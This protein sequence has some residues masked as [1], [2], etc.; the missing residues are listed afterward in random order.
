MSMINYKLEIKGTKENVTFGPRKPGEAGR[1]ILIIKNA[2]GAIED[3]SILVEGVDAPELNIYDPNG[4]FDCLEGKKV[5]DTQAATFDNTMQN[6]LRKYQL[7]NQFYILCYYFV[8]YAIPS[9]MAK[10]NTIL[11]EGMLESPLEDVAPEA[12]IADWV[13]SGE[14]KIHLS[15]GKTIDIGS[16]QGE[17]ISEYKSNAFLSNQLEIIVRMFDSEF[18]NLGEATLAIMHGWMPRTSLF[19]TGYYYDPRTFEKEEYAYDIVLLGLFNAFKE[20]SLS[21]KVQAEYEKQPATIDP[22][23]GL[24]KVSEGGYNYLDD[25][26]RQ[27][28]AKERV[29]FAADD[30]GA[31]QDSSVTTPFDFLENHFGAIRY[32][33]EARPWN[34]PTGPYKSPLYASLEIV[35]DKFPKP[36]S[37]ISRPEKQNKQALERIFEPDPFVN[38]DPFVIDEHRIGFFYK[39]AYN[40]ENLPPFSGSENYEQ[41]IRKL[42]DMA[43]TQVMSYYG[44]PRI[45]YLDTREAEY[46]TKFIGDMMQYFVEPNPSSDTLPSS[47]AYPRPAHDGS[48]LSDIYK[49]ELKDKIWVLATKT[50]HEA[51]E[52]GDSAEIYSEYERDPDGVLW[53]GGLIEPLIKFE[54]FRTPSLRRGD[55]Y[56]AKFIV[57]KSKLDYISKGFIER[58]TEE[59]E[60]ALVDATIDSVPKIDLLCTGS[61]GFGNSTENSERRYE[62]FKSIASKNKKEIARILR[63]KTLEAYNTQDFRGASNIDLGIFGSLGAENP[64]AATAAFLS[65]KLTNISQPLNPK[66]KSATSLSISYPDLKER[67]RSASD[68]LKKAFEFAIQEKIEFKFKGKQTGFNGVEKAFILA[69]VPIEVKRCIQKYGRS[70]FDFNDGASGM[71]KPDWVPDLNPL[72]QFS[73]FGLNEIHFKFKKLDGDCGLE[74]DSIR[75]GNNIITKSMIKEYASLNDPTVVSYLSQIYDMTGGTALDELKGGFITSFFTPPPISCTDIGIGK[76]GLGFLTRYTPC[77]KGEPMDDE[78]IKRWYQEEVEDPFNAWLNKSGNNLNSMFDPQFNK[79][80]LLSVLGKTADLKR[81]YRDFRN[82]I[83][84]SGFLCNILKCLQLPAINL[85][86]PELNLP[87][88]P[89]KIN[90]FGWYVGFVK[91]LIEAFFEVLVRILLSFFQMILDFLNFPF[92]EEQLRDELFGELSGSTPLLQEALVDGLLDIGLSKESMP[93]AKG[94]ISGAMSFLTGREICNLLKGEE[95]NPQSMS[96]LQDL[97]IKRGLGDDLGSPAAIRNFFESISIFIPDFC[98]DLESA[99]WVI[100]TT[101]CKETTSAAEQYRRRMMAGEATQE[102]MD[103][104]LELLDKNLLD[105]FEKLQAFS[106][107][108]IAGLLPDVV[109]F[110]NP[111]ALLNKLPNALEDQANQTIKNM[112]EPAKMSYL[113]SL[114]SFGPGLFFDT[115]RMPTPADNEFE[116]EAFITVTTIINNLNNYA[117]MLDT[118]AGREDADSEPELIAQLCALHTIYELEEDA[119]SGKKTLSAYEWVGEGTYNARKNLS[120]LFLENEA[121]NKKFRKL[122]FQQAA[123]LNSPRDTG[124][125]PIIYKPAG[126]S[127]DFYFNTDEDGNPISEKIANE[128]GKNMF[129]FESADRARKLSPR[130]G[131]H[132]LEGF[133]FQINYLIEKRA[134][135]DILDPDDDD[136]KIQEGLGPG[137]GKRTL[138]TAIK[139][140][141]DKMQMDLFSSLNVVSTPKVG[142][143]YLGTIRELFSQA[144]ETLT[145]NLKEGNRANELINIQS[146][147][148]EDNQ[149]VSSLLLNLKKGSLQATVKYN[150]F[151][152]VNSAEFDPYSIEIY[153]DNMFNRTEENP[154]TIEVCD[155]VPGPDNDSDSNQSNSIYREAIEEMNLTAGKNLYTRRELFARK[156]MSSLY[157]MSQKYYPSPAQNSSTQGFIKNL[158]PKKSDSYFKKGLVNKLYNRSTEGVFEQIFFALENSRIYDEESYYPGLNSRVAGQMYINQDNSC[159]KNRY[160]VSQLGLLSF[161]KMITDEIPKQLTSELSKPENAPENIDYDSP[162][163]VEKAIKN[164][165]FIGFIRIC[166]VELLLKGSLAYSVWDFEGVFDEKIFEEFVFEYIKSELLRKEIMKQNWEQMS[167]N[168]TGIQNPT[169]AL[170]KLVRNQSMKMLDV[171]KRIYRNK[172]ADIVDY[173]DWYSK[174]FIPQAHCS[175]N[176]AIK[177]GEVEE[178]YT[179]T[180]LQGQIKDSSTREQGRMKIDKFFWSHPLADERN[181]IIEDI[182]RRI[183]DVDIRSTSQDETSKIKDNATGL[184]RGNDPFFHIEHLVEVQGPLAA[185]ESIVIPGSLITESILNVDISRGEG[186]SDEARA[187]KKLTTKVSTRTPEKLNIQNSRNRTSLPALGLGDYGFEARPSQP[188]GSAGAAQEE[189]ANLVGGQGDVDPQKYAETTEVFNV[190]DF[191]SALNFEVTDKKMARFLNHMQGLMHYPGEGE[192]N[193][194]TEYPIPDAENPEFSGYPEEIKKLP[195]KFIKKT[196]RII[197]FKKDFVSGIFDDFIDGSSNFG[198]VE[199]YKKAMYKGSKSPSEHF[200]VVAPNGALAQGSLEAFRRFSAWKGELYEPQEEITEYYILPEN[201]EDLYKI[202][203]QIL[204]A[205]EAAGES[206]DGFELVDNTFAERSY[207]ADEMDME[208]AYDLLPEEAQ[209]FIEN[210]VGLKNDGDSVKVSFGRSFNN[211]RAKSDKKYGF[212]VPGLV[213]VNT[214]K[215]GNSAGVSHKESSL[216]FREITEGGKLTTRTSDARNSEVIIF[217]NKIGKFTSEQDYKNAINLLLTG[218]ETNSQ[219]AESLSSIVD[220]REE[221]WV[222]TVYEFSGE[223]AILA[224]V[225][226][227]YTIGETMD[228]AVFNFNPTQQ[229]KEAWAKVLEKH[230]VDSRLIFNQN[231]LVSYGR[232]FWPDDGQRGLSTGNE[233]DDISSRI[234]SRNMAIPYIARPMGIDKHTNRRLTSKLLVRAN[235]NTPGTPLFDDFMSLYAPF[236]RKDVIGKDGIATSTPMSDIPRPSAYAS[237]I[238]SN[239]N[240]IRNSATVPVWSTFNGAANNIHDGRTDDSTTYRDVCLLLHESPLF[241]PPTDNRDTSVITSTTGLLPPNVYKIPLRVLITQVYIKGSVKKAYCKVVPPKYIKNLKS[242]PADNTAQNLPEEVR[243]NIETL[244]QSITKICN[245]Y[246]Q[247]HSALEEIAGITTQDLQKGR[248]HIVDKFFSGFNRAYPEFTKDFTLNFDESINQENAEVDSEFSPVKREAS[249]LELDSPSQFCSV[250][251]IYS[252][253]F[254]LET[255]QNYWN[256]KEELDKLFA[257]D[258]GFLIRRKDINIEFNF[259]KD[260]TLPERIRHMESLNYFY[261]IPSSANIASTSTTSFHFHRTVFS[262]N[263]VLQWFLRYRHHNSL[264]GLMTPLNTQDVTTKNLGYGGKQKY[265]MSKVGAKYSQVNGTAQVKQNLLSSFPGSNAFRSPWQMGF[266]NTGGGSQRGRIS[267]DSFYSGYKIKTSTESD[268]KYFYSSTAYPEGAICL[269]HNYG[270]GILG[271]DVGAYGENSLNFVDDK[272]NKIIIK[273]RKLNVDDPYK[274]LYAPSGN[275]LVTKNTSV[276]FSQPLVDGYGDFYVNYNRLNGFPLMEN[277]GSIFVGDGR[278]SMDEVSITMKTLISSLFGDED[279]LDTLESIVLGDKMLFKDPA[280]NISN[281]NYKFIEDYLLNLGD[282]GQGITEINLDGFDPTN[283]PIAE[284]LNITIDQNLSGSQRRLSDNVDNIIERI[285]KFLN[286]LVTMCGTQIN[287]QTFYENDGKNS[288]FHSNHESL[289]QLS[290]IKRFVDKIN[291][292]TGTPHQ[293][294]MLLAYVSAYDFAKTI[295]K[296]FSPGGAISTVRRQ[297][298]ADWAFACLWWMHLWAAYAPKWYGDAGYTSPDGTPGRPQDIGKEG[299]AIWYGQGSRFGS[300]GMHLT[301]GNPRKTG[302]IN[303][304]LTDVDGIFKAREKEDIEAL[305]RIVPLMTRLKP[306]RFGGIVV[307]NGVITGVHRHGIYLKATDL[308]WDSL[309]SGE[310]RHGKRLGWYHSDNARHRITDEKIRRLLEGGSDN[311]SYHLGRPL[312]NKEIIESVYRICKYSFANNFRDHCRGSKPHRWSVMLFGGEALSSEATI[313]NPAEVIRE[314]LKAFASKSNYNSDGNKYVKSKAGYH[315]FSIHHKLRS[316][317]GRTFNAEGEDGK[318][319]VD[320]YYEAYAGGPDNQNTAFVDAINK[321][322]RNIEIGKLRKE[323]GYSETKSAHMMPVEDL[324]LLLARQQYEELGLEDY[325]KNIILAAQRSPNAARGYTFRKMLPIY[326]KKEFSGLTSVAA[327]MK[328]RW[329]NALRDYTGLPGVL[330]STMFDSA[331]IINNNVIGGLFENSKIDQVARLVINFPQVTKENTG[332]DTDIFSSDVFQ[333]MSEE[334]RSILMSIDDPASIADGNPNYTTA[335]DLNNMIL[336]VPV[337]EYREAMSKYGQSGD[338]EGDNFLVSCYSLDTLVENFENKTSWMTQ[339]LLATEGSKLFLKYIFPTKRFQALSTIFATTSLSGYSTMP[340]LMQAPKSSLSFMMGICSMSTKERLEIFKNMSQAELYKQLSDNKSSEPRA[341]GCFDLPFNADFLDG[342]MDMLLEQIKEFP[343]VLFRGIANIIDPAYKEMKMHYDACDIKNMTYRGWPSKTAHKPLGSISGGAHGPDGDKKYASLL[344]TSGWDLGWSISKL[345]SSP[346]TGAKGLGRTMSRL[347][348]YLYK[349]PLSLLDGNFQF[350]VPCKDEDISENWPGPFGASRYGHPYTPLTYI[351]LA[352]PELRGDKRLRQMSGRC[353]EQSELL[354]PS[355]AVLDRTSDCPEPPDSAFGEMPN[356]EEFDE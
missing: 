215:D 133:S 347:S 221:H 19:E 209:E 252:E 13:S 46:Q 96:M 85:S 141:I 258:R 298:E 68:D 228:P 229:T 330:T 148:T 72:K 314:S 282:E 269:D 137:L 193:D 78:P 131:N 197:K 214:S 7:D 44:K 187:V 206:G 14:N 287:F 222:E 10:K 345:F 217:E 283:N 245:D 109:D 288:I 270:H 4:W 293:K 333:L 198:S 174:Y 93:S 48:K 32:N 251:R 249:S 189:A 169:T 248:Q 325:K 144:N 28:A 244:N 140:R 69:N 341:M 257:S 201:A 172:P 95:I 36:D 297:A 178:R 108:G 3:Y 105:E 319:R 211:R 296:D 331:A 291:S 155:T 98:E 348:S 88:I 159:V 316:N 321:L 37:I 243:E 266:F 224:G 29:P 355:R 246:S 142:S 16:L 225:Y 220:V 107:Q 340:S 102:D 322:A 177:I 256:S 205:R 179:E 84:I 343:A 123:A 62:E 232:T 268:D 127:E 247:W 238:T 79:D 80:A 12:N 254:H 122:S 309:G 160:N 207:I 152:S 73:G 352:M 8:K 6:Y 335:M 101:S 52:L 180:D 200:G 332:I 17:E 34:T 9:A 23:A 264:W 35:S 313:Q 231:P 168:I 40:L 306:S 124:F 328:I 81:V 284:F 26:K 103:K 116:E 226:G 292:S 49:K 76:R 147:K 56:R 342:F 2:L 38:P 237:R 166:L 195:L 41:E 115:P 334:Q 111:D 134:E 54:E 273:K 191:K 290:I 24:L 302:T 53:Q 83:S 190:K 185:I 239:P 279:T 265:P 117:Q 212:E 312:T 91:A 138:Q 233:A 165:C 59:Q 210:Q 60:Q 276:I 45:F 208:A 82:K 260:L 61:D 305:E 20:G 1:D 182:E 213:K 289:K 241:L 307:E 194:D 261:D 203:K 339:E 300:D 97:A 324:S 356:P 121:R 349:G 153:N 92:C 5:S 151:P 354:S 317:L 272:G 71:P 350:Q 66:F 125:S 186:N 120:G 202:H 65:G 63:E 234:A 304:A 338:N 303:G 183:N 235:Q 149:N 294:I 196:R 74:I 281:K 204:E 240:Y 218:Q 318:K 308:K 113:S 119:S 114:S 110:G 22:V 181:I 47:D 315:H 27:V 132:N 164:V 129:N 146:N 351:A 175:R 143:E 104:A 184:I 310:R 188:A 154:I 250:E 176:I 216:P 259:L 253:A 67:T 42:E 55:T 99:N 150:E 199:E 327:V 353:N 139:N 43:L 286:H 242:R 25:Y 161:E 86:I 158:N 118:V 336:S 87:P 70:K 255:R 230:S 346:S 39:T 173:H 57:N 344:V 278:V 77:L 128:L 136:V 337:T 31:N 157:S 295:I 75:A 100:A 277:G 271:T 323:F 130:G 15:G 326:N 280:G 262:L 106:E 311:Y 30:S 301:W 90:I 274:Y 299:F 267:A 171:S 219:A 192:E 50:N 64:A 51:M 263:N 162:G 163:P 21:Q 18:G 167:I 156:I 126:F 227:S 145:E 112:F 275:D 285:L 89:P 329:H 94:F 58:L 320:R 170:R 236:G 223:S 33:L 11:V 135:K